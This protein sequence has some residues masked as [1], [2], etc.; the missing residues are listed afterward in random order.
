MLRVL[1]RHK[2]KTFE[3]FEAVQKST[4]RGRQRAA[5]Q[6]EAVENGHST[7]CEEWTSDLWLHCLLPHASIQHDDRTPEQQAEMDWYE[8]I[9]NSAAKAAYDAATMLGLALNKEI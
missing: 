5:W 3:L 1:E 2:M 9:I 7:T 4:M 6:L 8:T